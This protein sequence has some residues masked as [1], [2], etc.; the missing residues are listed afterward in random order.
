MTK[1][2]TRSR[3]GFLSAIACLTHLSLFAFATAQFAGAAS[4]GEK[5]D[6]TTFGMHLVAGPPERIHLRGFSLLTP[7][8]GKWCT[9]GPNM[10]NTE[11]FLYK[12]T[13]YGR[14]AAEVTAEEKAQS[15]YLR[16]RLM[17]VP[18]SVTV[19]IEALLRFTKSLRDQY[20]VGRF[21]LMSFDAVR[22]DLPGFQCVRRGLSQL[23][24]ENP[25]Y[26]GLDLIIEAVDYLCLNPGSANTVIEV[27]Y[28]E[29]YIE[30]RRPGPSLM[31]ELAPELEPV[32]QSLRVETDAL[33]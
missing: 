3:S 30:D 14:T 31:M 2:A 23:E 7:G 24:L 29:R 19:N 8:G 32:L 12:A 5:S 25:I 28:S 10:Q 27:E 16:A 13:V 1:S 33:R 18:E 9:R 22:N 17:G 11:I 6:C 21:T 4:P 15:F 26:P 20:H